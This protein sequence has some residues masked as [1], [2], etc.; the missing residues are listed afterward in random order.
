MFIDILGDKGGAR[1]T[2]RD[3]FEFFDAQTLETTVMDY[4]IEPMHYVEDVAFVESLYTGEKTRSHIDNV[5]ESAKLL[6]ALYRSSEIG[7]EV[8]LS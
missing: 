2:Y 3:K 6:D 8:A 4:D 7:K 5:L 1:F